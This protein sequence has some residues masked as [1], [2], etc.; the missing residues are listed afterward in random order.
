MTKLFSL[1]SKS[2]LLYF[3]LWC[4]DC[5][6]TNP[7]FA[8]QLFPYSLCPYRVLQRDARLEEE[9]GTCSFLFTSCLLLEFPVH[10]L[11][12]WESPQPLFLISAVAVH[13]CSSSWIQFAVFATLAEPVSSC[14]CPRS[15]STSLP[16]FL[17]QMYESRPH[18]ASS[19][20]TKTTS[21]SQ[22]VFLPQASV[23]WLHAV[24]LSS[25]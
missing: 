12:L 14:P 3:A 11:V 4:W 15:T 8:C 10:F 7:I 17:P 21:A 18:E 25:F 5:N 16:A 20:S 2:N 22:L 23:F 6:S 13:F 19:F 1:S 9:E 24:P